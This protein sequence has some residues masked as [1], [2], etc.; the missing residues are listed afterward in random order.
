M[1]LVNIAVVLVAVGVILWL[2]NTY[3]PMAGAMKSLLNLVAFVVVVVWLLQG[4][5]LIGSISGLHM[6]TI[7]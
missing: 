4:F 7:R 2:I 1:N 5:G 6:P 3:I